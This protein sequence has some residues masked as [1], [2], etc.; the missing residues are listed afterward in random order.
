MKEYIVIIAKHA[1]RILTCSLGGLG[2]GFLIQ[3]LTP[4]KVSQHLLDFF[5][6]VF[7]GTA[8]LAITTIYFP[9]ANTKQ[10]VWETVIYALIAL[11]IYKAF[12]WQIFDFILKLIRRK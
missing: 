8:S 2:F 12:G 3:T 5:V 4:W 10:L 9:T 6:V 11:T 7:I 1:V